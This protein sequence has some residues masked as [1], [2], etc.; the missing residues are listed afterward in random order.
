[1][2]GD[3]VREEH[4]MLTL[5]TSTTGQVGRRFIQRLLA[6]RQ[7]GEQVRVLVRDAARGERFA[8][9]GAHVTVGDMRDEETLG[10]ALAGMDA[11]PGPRGDRR[12]GG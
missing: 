8:A 1:M 10:K 12:Q 7:P 4:I 11:A 5:V 2:T 9:L 6:Q 3:T